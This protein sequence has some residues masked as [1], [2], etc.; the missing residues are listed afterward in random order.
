MLDSYPKHL[1]LFMISFQHKKNIKFMLNITYK[2]C[3]HRWSSISIL[4]HCLLTF[5]GWKIT[6]TLLFCKRLWWCWRLPGP[7]THKAAVAA[8]RAVTQIRVHQTCLLC[9]CCLLKLCCVEGMLSSDVY[10]YL[11]FFLLCVLICVCGC[12]S[13]VQFA[14]PFTPSAN[15]FIDQTKAV[16]NSWV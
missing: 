11:I 9:V 7:H 13:V 4:W 10:R 8:T 1:T 3:A 14:W 15:S 16:T 6:G 12:P 2:F 5:S